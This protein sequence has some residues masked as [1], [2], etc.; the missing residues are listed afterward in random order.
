[1]GLGEACGDSSNEDCLCVRGRVGQKGL[2]EGEGG[3]E[4]KAGGRGGDAG[5]GGRVS[6][7]GGGGE[8]RRQDVAS[9]SR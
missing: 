8:G 2:K 1:M 5:H 9:W 3:D 4:G 7:E 6:G